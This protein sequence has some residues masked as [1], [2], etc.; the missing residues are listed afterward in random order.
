MGI[1]AMGEV[2]LTGGDAIIF[3]LLAYPAYPTE[4][5]LEV[6]RPDSN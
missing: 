6:E 2:T 1:A 5:G 3:Y 4:S